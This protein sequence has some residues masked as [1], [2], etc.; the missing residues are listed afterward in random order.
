MKGE[1]RCQ[2]PQRVLVY[3]YLCY[4]LYAGSC[5]IFVSMYVHACVL[6]DVFVRVHVYVLHINALCAGM[7]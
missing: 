7:C 5:V 3:V 2:E 1:M 4:I 6:M